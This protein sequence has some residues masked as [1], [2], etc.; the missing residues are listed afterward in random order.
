M[1]LTDIIFGKQQ[2]E[3]RTL[4]P[5][6]PAGARLDASVSESHV[7]SAEIVSH[8]VEIGIDV[9]DHIRRLPRTLEINGV[10]TNTPVIFAASLQ[11]LSPANSPAIGA[12]APSSDRVSA[13]YDSLRKC[14]ENGYLLL[15]STS[16]RT[17]VNMAIESIAVRREAT[18]GNI[19]DC[20]ITLR[21]VLLAFSLAEDVPVPVDKANQ[22]AKNAGKK[23]KEV[24]SSAQDA[25]AQQ[26]AS[27]FKQAASLVGFG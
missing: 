10:V 20:T 4:P 15:V 17:Y 22:A 8:P 5:N 2:V 11:S 25:T 27:V 16:L 19:L 18:T 7:D 26:S 21:E 24:G 6:P 9:S 3:L 14:M 12:L 13:G 1:G 23:G